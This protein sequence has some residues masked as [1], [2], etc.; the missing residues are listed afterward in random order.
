MVLC[1]LCLDLFVK[2]KINLKDISL[3][4][5]QENPIFLSVDRR[6]PKDVFGIGYMQ[7]FQFKKEIR[8]PEDFDDVGKIDHVFC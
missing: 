8:M 5:S 7:L 6:S 2:T 3:L 1:I 4:W